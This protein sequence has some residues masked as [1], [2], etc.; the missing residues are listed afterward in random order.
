[1]HLLAFDDLRRTD[2]V[3]T[4]QLHVRTGPEL[5]IPDVV[6]FINGIP[7]VV[8]EAKTPVR[9]A[10][11]WLDGAHDISAVYE[12]AI[13]PFFVPT[14]LSFATEGKELFYGAVRTPLDFWAPWRLED[15][16]PDALAKLV[17]MQE[18]G[19][20]LTSLLRPAMLL[21]MLRSFTFYATTARK[22]KMK[23]VARYQQVE[24]ANAIVARVAEGVGEEGVAV[25]LP[26][27]G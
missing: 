25:A 17:G 1:M 9:P 23:L 14:I 19:K 15:D 2:Y 13:T 10:I 12:V 26:G 4:N 18:V 3:V 16:T 21:D 5:K 22:Q 8:G 27:V 20:Q 11:S 24:G 7:V 6:C